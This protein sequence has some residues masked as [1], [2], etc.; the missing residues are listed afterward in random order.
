MKKFKLTLARMNRDLGVSLRVRRYFRMIPGEP[1]LYAVRR[2]RLCQADVVLCLLRLGCRRARN[3]IAEFI[4][5]PITVCPPQRRT[6]P[7]TKDEKKLRIKWVQRSN[8]RHPNT[9]AHERFEIFRAGRSIE[10]CI[11]RGATARDVRSAVRRGWI[12]V[13]TI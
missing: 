9:G 4:G 5:H 3:W 13:S 8:P 11:M 6:H 12:H 1:L 10:E 2:L 7:I